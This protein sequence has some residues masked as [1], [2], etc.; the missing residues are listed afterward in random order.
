MVIARVQFLSYEEGG[1]ASLPSSGYHPQVAIG[2][3]QTSCVIES[4][5][6][7]T[8]FAFDKEHLVSLRLTFPDHYLNAFAVGQAVYFYEGGHLVGSGVV[9]E[10]E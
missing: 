8:T 2:N 6:G 7:E 4:L 10:V 1:R 3:E 5:D 9:L